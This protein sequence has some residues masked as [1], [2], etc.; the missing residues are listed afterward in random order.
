MAFH[1]VSLKL[2]NKSFKS[3]VSTEGCTFVADLLGVIK[4]TFSHCLLLTLSLNSLSLDLMDSANSTQKLLLLIL[5]VLKNSSLT[6]EQSTEVSCRKYL[7]ALTMAFFIQ[8]DLP[9]QY[10]K[11]TMCNVLAAYRGQQGKCEQTSLWATWWDYRQNDGVPLT[12]EPLTSRL[13]AK[14]WETL[15]ELNRETSDR[16]HDARLPLTINQKPFIVLPHNDFVD[17]G[18]MNG[19]KSIAATI[20]VVS[21]EADF[22]VKDEEDLS[23]SSSSESE[24]P[25][26]DMEMY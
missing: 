19:L 13:T 14:Q 10:D 11:P 9:T 12:N 20:G 17:K 21:T 25:D 24:S 1:Y 5:V 15:D 26:K 3:K 16:I 8:Y 7:D 2:G 23:S 18:T 4:T 6:K 22:I